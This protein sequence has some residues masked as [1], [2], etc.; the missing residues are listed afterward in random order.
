MKKDLTDEFFKRNM[1]I[2][3][4]HIVFG[5]LRPGDLVP[6]SGGKCSSLKDGKLHQVQ[7][8]VNAAQS[9]QRRYW[10]RHSDAYRVVTRR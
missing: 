3:N 2:E 8:D 5:D 10:L 6:R 1:E 7:A 9:L 4:P